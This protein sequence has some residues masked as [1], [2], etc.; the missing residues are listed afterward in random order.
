MQLRVPK[1]SSA[2]GAG[3]GQ[4]VCGGRVRLVLGQSGAEDPSS[5]RQTAPEESAGPGVRHR[6]L[7][8]AV[9]AT[10]VG[11]ALSPSCSPV[12]CFL[13]ELL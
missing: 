9:P 7:P 1:H 12:N 3:K 5:R 2:V 8:G 10:Q 11:T 13:V 4:A 6:R